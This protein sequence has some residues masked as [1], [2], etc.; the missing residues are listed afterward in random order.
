MSDWKSEKAGQFA[1]DF[2]LEIPDYSK[3]GDDKEDL[4]I[5][6]FEAMREAEE[7]GR[8]EENEAIAKLQCYGCRDNMKTFPEGK[9][10]RHIDIERD[11]LIYCNAQNIRARMEEE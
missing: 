9:Y 3:W 6:F 7:H 2:M 4:E 5:K 1:A 11:C 10:T 8:R